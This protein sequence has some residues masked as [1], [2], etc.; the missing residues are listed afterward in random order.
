MIPSV[1]ENHFLLLFFEHI[2]NNIMNNSMFVLYAITP[3]IV[4]YMYSDNEQL[5]SKKNSCF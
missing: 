4:L 3:T 5:Y 2:S 1:D